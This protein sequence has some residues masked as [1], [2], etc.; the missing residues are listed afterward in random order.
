MANSKS[1]M[2]AT[3]NGIIGNANAGPQK[4][5]I[6]LNYTNRHIFL[7]QERDKMTRGQEI[8]KIRKTLRMGRKSFAAVCLRRSE[9]SVIKY[10]DGSV[11]PPDI[12]MERARKWHELY[13]EIH[14]VRRR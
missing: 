5:H 1:W 9:P 2:A 4:K 11:N 14:E 7:I 13:N 3:Y 10:E 12:I 8:L 6:Q